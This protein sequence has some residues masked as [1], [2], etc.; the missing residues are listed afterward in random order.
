VRAV[1]IQDAAGFRLDEIYRYARDKWGEAQAARYI[2]GLFAAFDSIGSGKA[3]SR[4]IPAAFGV[5]GFFVR[6]ES[7]FIYWRDMPNGDVGIVTI[8]RARMHQIE[9]FREDFG[10]G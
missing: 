3:A 10:G 8:L 5:N 9:R 6:Y 1:R 2:E 4:P 7:H